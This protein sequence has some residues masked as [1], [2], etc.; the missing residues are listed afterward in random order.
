MTRLDDRFQQLRRDGQKGF[1]AFVTAGDPDLDATREIALRLE[2]AGVDCLELGVPFSDP[3]ADGPVIREASERALKTGATLPK[4]LELVADLRT[5][6]QLPLIMF[7]YL[8][9]IFR[10]GVERFARDARESGVDGV[11]LTDLPPEEAEAFRAPLRAS[12]LDTVFLVAPT[13]TDDR[14][15]RITGL[16]SGF[17]Y[18]ISRLGV[19]GV[20]ENVDQAVRPLVSRVRAHTDKPLAV[21]FGISRPEHAAQVAEVADAV[22]VGSALVRVVANNVGSPD[23]ARCVAQTAGEIVKGLGR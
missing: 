16:S 7:S 15:K 18:C 20:R 8:N 12:G 14:V 2:E 5:Q 17:V 3:I 9:P 23:V 10:Y 11:L 19:T 22:V 13:S 6:T 4:I 1:V 21:G